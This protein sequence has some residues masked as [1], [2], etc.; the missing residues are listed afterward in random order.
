VSKEVPRQAAAEEETPAPKGKLV[1][2]RLL[3]TQDWLKQ[4]PD[5]HYAIQLLTVKESDL[6][7]LETF[8]R[9]ATAE[10][11]NQPFHVYRVK[12]DGVQHYRAAYGMYPDVSSVRAAMK[13]LPPLL[14]AQNPYHRSV[15][16]MRSQNRQ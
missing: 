6:G 8:L 15:E 16:R 14:R 11:G 12:I 7:R 2:E 4:A 3:A 10:L 13:E 5:D 1:Q 9:K